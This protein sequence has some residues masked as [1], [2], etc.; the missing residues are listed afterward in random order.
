MRELLQSHVPVRSLLQVAAEADGRLD[1]RLRYIHA[2]A[3]GRAVGAAR[4]AHVLWWRLCSA[5]HARVGMATAHVAAAERFARASQLDRGGALHG[6]TVG[7]VA[8]AGTQRRRDA[9]ARVRS[10]DDRP[11]RRSPRLRLPTRAAPHALLCLV[12]R[13]ELHVRR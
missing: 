10:K 6:A 9:D 1:Q 13:A 11:L 12:E 5:A 3:A 4:V 8:L 2:T 7:T